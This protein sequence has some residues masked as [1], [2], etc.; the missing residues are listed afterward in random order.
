MYVIN[1]KT[2]AKIKVTV[3]CDILP[4]SKYNPTEISW[5]TH[6]MEERI[7]AASNILHSLETFEILTLWGDYNKRTLLVKSVFYF[8]IVIKI[9]RGTL[10]YRCHNS[11]ARTL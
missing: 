1:A 5:R 3:A 10:I 11:P 6:I 8:L 7:I 9:Q 4:F 2:S